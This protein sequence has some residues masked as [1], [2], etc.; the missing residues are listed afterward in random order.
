MIKSKSNYFNSSLLMNQA[1]LQLLEKKDL[2]FITVKEICQKAGVNRSTFYLH[3]ENIGDLLKETLENL[4]KQFM[5]SFPNEDIFKMLQS[6]TANEMIFIKKEY[7][8]PYLNFIKNNIR[9]FKTIHE[10]K[11]VFKNDFVYAEMCNEIFYPILS[12]FKVREK[13]KPFILE[14]YTK[15]IIGIIDKWLETNCQEEIDF[16]INLIIDCV[17][18]KNFK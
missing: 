6:S 5:Q 17:G 2:S 9:L 3:Y 18:V 7:L 14:F 1:L 4:N 12:K 10:K 16:I 11:Y 15:G 8:E 13:D